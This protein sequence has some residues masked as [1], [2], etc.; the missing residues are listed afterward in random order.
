MNFTQSFLSRS[1]LLSLFKIEKQLRAK[2]FS[3]FFIS[4]YRRIIFQILFTVLLIFFLTDVSLLTSLCA[5]VFMNNSLIIFIGIKLDESK[6]VENL[7]CIF[8]FGFLPLVS[9]CTRTVRE[10]LI[11]CIIQI[12]CCFLYRCWFFFNTKTFYCPL[13]PLF[14]VFLF[15][16]PRLM[17]SKKLEKFCLLDKI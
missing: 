5:K 6:K 10:K 3:F 9:M 7:Y 1:Q 12:L 13:S 15:A 11:I 14:L 2:A 17:I 16:F 4:T 8:K